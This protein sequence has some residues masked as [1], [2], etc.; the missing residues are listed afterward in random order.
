MT[1][2][3]E[4]TQ[5][6]VKLIATDTQNNA[7]DI[8]DLISG[9]T[10]VLSLRAETLEKKQ[11]PGLKA[12]L[13]EVVQWTGFLLTAASAL[14]AFLQMWLKQRPS[15]VIRLHGPDTELIVQCNSHEDRD[16]VFDWI[17]S[18]T[19]GNVT[20]EVIKVKQ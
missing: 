15:Y 20:I 1:G 7:A 12:D 2:R 9:I 3:T 13:P 8:M 4:E 14:V 19:N 10:E 16:R 17:K 5:N 18:N 6:V 11:L